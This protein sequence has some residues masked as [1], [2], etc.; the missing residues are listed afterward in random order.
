MDNWERDRELD[1]GFVRMYLTV[2]ATRMDET[3]ERECDCQ[4]DES[5][6]PGYSPQVFKYSSQCCCKGVL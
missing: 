3:I 5:L 4:F 2:M 1:L 6:W